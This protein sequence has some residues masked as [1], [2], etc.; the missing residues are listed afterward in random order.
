MLAG[1]DNRKMRPEYR[2][3]KIDPAKLKKP[4]LAP[5]HVARIEDGLK[6]AGYE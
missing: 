5:E 6:R 2:Q 3:S 4:E 1:T